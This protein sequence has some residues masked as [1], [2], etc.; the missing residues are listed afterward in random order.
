M[1]KRML[2]MILALVVL[3]GLIFL[4]KAFSAWMMRRYA[5]AHRN[6][7][8]T[9]STMK[10]E[11]SLWQ[12]QLKSVGTVRAIKGV[13]V[14]TELAGLVQTI[15]FTPGKV[16]KTGTV[17]VQL[18]AGTE[19]GQ[20]EALNAQTEIA[21]ITLIRDKK[22][23]LAR[24]VSEQQVQNDQYNLQNLQ[25]QVSS[26][27]ATVAKKTIR[28]PFDGRLGISNVN[29]GQYLN[30]GD[31]VVTLQSLDPIWVDFYLP[32]QALAQLRFGQTVNITTDTFPHKKYVGTITTI[33]PLVDT[34]TRNVEVEATVSN[35]NYELTPGMYTTIEVDTGKPSSFLTLPQSAVSFNPYGDIVYVVKEKG[36]DKAGKPILTANQIFVTT[37]ETRGDQVTI[38]RGLKEGETVVTSGQLKLRNGSLIAVN[39][40]VQPANNPNPTVSNEHKSLS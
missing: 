7:V 2:I 35:Q 23:F 39:N 25:G 12:S 40:S 21:K 5:E 27:A 14:T 19:I 37:G 33:Q 22:Q 11:K 10:V 28:A 18:N 32:Q 6:P 24:A 20:L 13:N 16:V 1:K 31:T 30:V 17:L 38:L 9:V 26:Q 8:M 15:Y 3:F 29:P 4:Y 34:N 36:K